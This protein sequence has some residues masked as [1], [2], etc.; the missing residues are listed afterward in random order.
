MNVA[1]QITNGSQPL[2]AV[3]VGAFGVTWSSMQYMHHYAT[4]RHVHKGARNLRTWRWLDA[5]WLNHNWHQRHH[6]QPNVPWIHLP[7]LDRGPAAPR[8]SM[9][10][11]PSASFR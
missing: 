2:G 9:A 8:E 5:L 4:E 1:K 11:S 7:Q 3:L 6:E 10:T